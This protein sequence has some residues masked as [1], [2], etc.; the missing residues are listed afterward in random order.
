MLLLKSAWSLLQV[1]LPLS[2]CGLKNEVHNRV[3]PS[4]KYRTQACAVGDP[5]RAQDIPYKSTSP[6]THTVP[7]IPVMQRICDAT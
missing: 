7:Y 6:T 3:A 1:G 2:I 4:V 5:L